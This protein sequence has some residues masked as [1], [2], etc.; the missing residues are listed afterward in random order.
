MPTYRLIDDVHHAFAGGMPQV[1]VE[2]AAEGKRGSS[3]VMDFDEWVPFP[4][5]QFTTEDPA[6][7]EKLE[8]IAV[9][10]RMQGEP[11]QIYRVDP[12]TEEVTVTASE[13]EELESLRAQ[14][15]ALAVAQRRGDPVPDPRGSISERDGYDPTKDPDSPEFGKRQCPLCNEWFHGKG[16]QGHLSLNREARHREYWAELKARGEI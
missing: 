4:N 7:I 8:R 3:Q 12:R 15:A 6:L 9:A 13:Y 5:G 14:M 1:M 10:D 11:G 2:P 16:F